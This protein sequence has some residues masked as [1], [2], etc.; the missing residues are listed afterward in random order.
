MTP[1]CRE[2]ACAYRHSTTSHVEEELVEVAGSGAP[3]P[4]TTTATPTGQP[5]GASQPVIRWNHAAATTG[6]V[7]LH[8]SPAGGQTWFEAIIIGDAV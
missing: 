3:V 2:Y 5:F 8:C 7:L 6:D 4:G 1:T